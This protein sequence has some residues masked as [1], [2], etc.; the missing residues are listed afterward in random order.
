[1]SYI[2]C[3]GGIR[4]YIDE[5]TFFNQV[6][7]TNKKMLVFGTGSLAE[8]FMLNN[9]WLYKYVGFFIDSTP[10]SSSYMGRDVISFKEFQE[11]DNLNEYFILVA[12]SFYKEIFKQLN[13]IGLKKDEHYIQVTEKEIN[14]QTTVDRIVQG[15]KV[16]RFTYGYSKHCYPGSILKQI[17]SFTSIHD[18]VRIGEINHPLNFI[19]THPILYTTENEFSGSEGVPG[20]LAES[21]VI[22]I[23]SI[24]SNEKIAIG[25]DV[26]IGANAV[27]LPGV[28]IGDGA[29]IGAGAVVTKDVPP[30]AIMGGVPSK[31]IRYRFTPEE[32]E[33]LLNIKWWEWEIEE[34]KS[35]AHLLKN[36]ALFLKNMD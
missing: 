12:S 22:D 13:S 28:T 31:V 36:P 6:V 19:T 21:E 9:P 18:S 29:V 33:I 7:T 24:P 30:Y 35:K 2:D 10:R 23:R 34:I 4:V 11:Q 32:I 14:P 1:M 17:G 5:A 8:K 20:I 15:V 3:Y 26:W 16:G 27:I 25:N